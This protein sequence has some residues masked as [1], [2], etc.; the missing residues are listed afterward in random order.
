MS[1][2]TGR[3][4]MEGRLAE[5]SLQDES[6]ARGCSEDPKAA[7]EDERTQLPED[8]R[9]Q[10]VEETA[11]TIYLVLPAPHRSAKAASSPTGS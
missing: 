8:V 4:E 2:G 7:V 9:V 1:E 6:S 3:A 5:R 10:A 11:E